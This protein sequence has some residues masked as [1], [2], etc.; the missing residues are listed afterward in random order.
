MP[1]PLSALL[2]LVTTDSADSPNIVGAR[3]PAMPAAPHS[4]ALAAAARLISC[5]Q[6]AS[7][8]SSGGR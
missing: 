6:S 1:P 2:M 3:L 5:V 8:N 7:W 4:G